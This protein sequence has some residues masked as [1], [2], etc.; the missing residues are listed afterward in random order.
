MGYRYGLH[1]KDLP[2]KPDIVLTRHKKAIFVHGCYWHGHGCS[3]G[4]LPKSRTDYW[5]S[6]I[7]IN[8]ARDRRNL[9]SLHLLG[10][11]SLVL[12][13]CEIKNHESLKQQLLSFLNE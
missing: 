1:R 13:Q 5:G 6:K 11:G 3:K 7:A 9:D 2:G 8:Q 4:Q 10:W 12:W